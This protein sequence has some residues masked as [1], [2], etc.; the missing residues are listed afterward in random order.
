MEENK[1]ITL[2]NKDMTP[3]LLVKL[4]DDGYKRYLEGEKWNPD[5]IE[6]MMDIRAIEKAEF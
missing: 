5:W 6:L 2:Y 4:T 1:Y 3:V